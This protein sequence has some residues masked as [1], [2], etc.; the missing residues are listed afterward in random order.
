VNTE[1]TD[2]M[3]ARGQN[4]VCYDAECGICVRWAERFRGLLERRGFILLPLQS[5]AVRDTLRMPEDELLAEMRVITSAGRVFGGAD[6][7]VYL[8]NTIFKP[9]FWLAHVPGVKPILRSGYRFIA[10]NRD[11]GHGVCANRRFDTQKASPQNPEHPLCPA[12]RRG[13][14]GNRAPGVRSFRV[15]NPADWLPLLIL[16]P[17]AAVIGTRFPA[18]IYMWLLAFALFVGCKWLCYRRELAKGTLTSRARKIGFLF[19]WIGMDAA[20]FLSSETKATT[21]RASE[22][23]FAVVKTLFGAILLWGGARLAL[24]IHPL[25]AGWTGMLGIIL[26]LHFGFF[27]LLALAWRAAGVPVTPLMRAPLL[28]RSVGE[29]WGNRW[30]TAFHELTTTFLF[31]PLRRVAD[32]RAAILLVFLASGL[33]HDFVISIPARGGYGLPTLYFLLQGAAVLFEHT[34]IARRFGLGRGIRGWLFMFLVTAGP[35][36]WL[37]HPPFIHHVILPMLHAIGAT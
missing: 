11:C 26:L 19:G 4:W 32:M 9:L 23:I 16:P 21:P 18:W 29:F 27:H 5:A 8:S 3:N 6:A 31:H 15:G 34:K 28:S 14:G 36:F 17:T 22:W 2:T 30:N 35:A 24:T 12:P 10:R 37:F 20:K 1:I 33:I 13:G 7:L 25:L